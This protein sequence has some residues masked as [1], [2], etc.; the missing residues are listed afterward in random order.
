MALRRG[1]FA[2]ADAVFYVQDDGARTG[3]EGWSLVV[4]LEEVRAA[5]VH[6]AFMGRGAG[7]R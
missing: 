4:Q 7:S 3:G 5:H 2:S 1:A 6:G